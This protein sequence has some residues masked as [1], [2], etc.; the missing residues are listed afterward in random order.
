M[1]NEHPFCRNVSGGA[2]MRCAAVEALSLES[3]ELRGRSSLGT[4]WRVSAGVVDIVGRLGET[5]KRGFEMLMLGVEEGAEADAESK[6][7]GEISYLSPDSKLPY[8]SD[9]FALRSPVPLTDAM[10]VAANPR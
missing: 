7:K 5:A 6:F 10:W 2:L 8:F 4:R 1:V 3:M 9:M